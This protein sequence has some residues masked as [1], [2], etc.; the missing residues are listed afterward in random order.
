MYFAFDNPSL[1]MITGGAWEL[2]MYPH[3]PRKYKPSDIIFTFFLDFNDVLLQ[4]DVIQLSDCC[5]LYFHLKTTPIKDEDSDIIFSEEYDPRPNHFRNLRRGTTLIEKRIGQFFR[6]EKVFY[7]DN[8][9]G[10]IVRNYLSV[11]SQ[12]SL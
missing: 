5:F 11:C 1:S 3:C 8:D 6:M 12:S 7:Q 9:V 10:E 2:A 4:G